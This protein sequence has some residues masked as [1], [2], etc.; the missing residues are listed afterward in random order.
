MDQST[1]LCARCGIAPRNSSLRSYCVDCKRALAQ[2]SRD[3]RGQWKKPQPYCSRCG[4]ERTGRHPSYCVECWRIKREER[5]TEPCSRCGRERDPADTARTVYCHDCWRDWWLRR[6]YGLTSEQYE[7]M[8]A[9]QD[10]RCRICRT[11]ANGRTWHVDHNHETGIVRGIL[12]DNCNRGLGHFK[13][14]ADL[15]RRAAD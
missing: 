8:L 9:K 13:D 15:L 3:R 7:Q 6:K 14:D 4:N 5:L 2:E 12:C 11:E 10:G 1:K